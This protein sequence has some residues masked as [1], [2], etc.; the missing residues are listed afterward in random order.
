[1]FGNPINVDQRIHLQQVNPPHQQEMDR[2]IAEMALTLLPPP[3]EPELSFEQ[4]Q[5]MD[6]AALQDYSSRAY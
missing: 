3:L 1:M 6:I 2:K 5:R 4:R